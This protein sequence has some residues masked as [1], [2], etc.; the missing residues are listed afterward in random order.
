MRK[1]ILIVLILTLGI[2][3][4]ESKS[5]SDKKQNEVPEIP[6]ELNGFSMEQIKNIHQYMNVDRWNN[7]GDIGTRMGTDYNKLAEKLNIP[8]SKLKEIDSYYHYDVIKILDKKIKSQFENHKN[9]EPD[10]YGSIESTAYCG[11][12]TLRGNIV[13]YGQKNIANF[14]AEAEKIANELI[15]EIPD[16]I[17]GYKLNFT[18]YEDPNLETKGNVD[19]GFLW[20][21]GEELKVMK[22]SRG[23]Y[24]YKRPETN[25]FWHNREWNNE[26][27]IPNPNL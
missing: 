14:K 3:C 1:L 26:S 2:S 6:A 18:R 20:R 13:V 8:I 11:I 21:K 22:S 25:T 23:L 10:Y 24:G 12:N 27:T 4:K 5:E 7:G 19:I 16:W 15:S 9:F 17:T